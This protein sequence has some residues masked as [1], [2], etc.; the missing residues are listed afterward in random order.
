MGGKK[1]EQ[2]KPT[3]SKY[4]N[5]TDMNLNS[6]KFISGASAVDVSIMRAEDSALNDDACAGDVAL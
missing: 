5:G 3:Y 4:A 1:T 6:T 2:H